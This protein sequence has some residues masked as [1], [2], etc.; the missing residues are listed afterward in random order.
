MNTNIKYM[1]IVC[2]YIIY[3]HV[4][5]YIYHIY[6]CIYHIYTCI[7]IIFS[8]TTFQIGITPEVFEGFTP[9]RVHLKG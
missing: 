3:I 5:V 1:Y 4:H 7:Y 2:I 9:S 6:T 8:N